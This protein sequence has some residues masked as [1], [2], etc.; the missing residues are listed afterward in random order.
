MQLRQTA[1]ALL[2]DGGLLPLSSH[3][4][5]AQ[6]GCPKPGAG[7]KCFI[8]QISRLGERHGEGWFITPALGC[9]QLHLWLLSAVLLWDTWLHTQG[10]LG[11]SPSV[12]AARL[13]GAVCRGGDTRELQG[14]KGFPGQ[15]GFLETFPQTR[16]LTLWPQQEWEGREH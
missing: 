16:W 14:Q 9:E 13:L 6:S 11:V 7:L 1:G 4:S 15:G 5:R 10:T 2:S 12:A 3:V 8:N